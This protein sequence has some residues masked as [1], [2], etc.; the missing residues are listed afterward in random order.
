MRKRLLFLSTLGAGL[1][2]AL[3]SGADDKV[4]AIQAGGGFSSGHQGSALS[5]NWKAL[6]F[7]PDGTGGTGAL[8]LCPSGNDIINNGASCSSIDVILTEDGSPLKNYWITSDV[9]PGWGYTQ[10]CKTV[11]GVQTCTS[12]L[13]GKNGIIAR[14]SLDDDSDLVLAKLV[15]VSALG[16]GS[17]CSQIWNV[18]SPIG[19]NPVCVQTSDCL[20]FAA[21]DVCNNGLCVDPPPP[22]PPLPL[23][24]TTCFQENGVLNPNDN[25]RPA[26]CSDA[27]PGWCSNPGDTISEYDDP[28]WGSIANGDMDP[29]T[30][31]SYAFRGCYCNANTAGLFLLSSTGHYLNR[32]WDATLLGGFGAWV[33]TPANTLCPEMTAAFTTVAQSPIEKALQVPIVG[34]LFTWTGSAWQ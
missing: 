32:V 13:G 28:T 20:K 11:K 9:L 12:A 22:P 24:A 23:S 1:L 10:T 17:P 34:Q 6:N 4:C 25:S 21:G 8:W 15:N 30:A 16:F 29:R 7:Y 3:N 33:W 19:G 18:L 31:F 26:V 27:R 14:F 5:G 2:A